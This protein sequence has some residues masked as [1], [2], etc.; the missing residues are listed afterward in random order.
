MSDAKFNI[1]T[2]GQLH[3]GVSEDTAVERLSSLLSIE[4]E[5]ARTMLQTPGTIIRSGLSYAQLQLL[6][7]KLSEAG[8]GVDETPDES[9]AVVR[10]YDVVFSGQSREYFR[11]WSVNLMLTLIT[12][13]FYSPWAKVRNNQ[14]LY[15]HV[16]LDQSA[17]QYTANPWAI[18][19]G[20][21]L[22]LVAFIAY[23]AA[24]TFL[25]VVGAALG[26]FFL[27][28]MPAIINRALSFQLANTRYRNLRFGFRGSYAEAAWVFLG[29]PFLIPLT[30]GMITPYWWYRK[31]RYL[32][33]R[34]YYGN[35]AFQF[36][37]RASDY[38][39]M[40][41][42]ISL[43]II[44]VLIA[45]VVLSLLDLSLLSG[46]LIAIGYLLAFSY[47]ATATTNLRFNFTTNRG[48][49]FRSQMQ[50][51]KMVSLYV[52]NT[53]LIVITLGLAIP[54]ARVRMARY[55]AKTLQVIARGSLN[56]FVAAE[57]EH[58]SA[59]GEQ[60]GEMFDVDIPVI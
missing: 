41:F 28:L 35:S 56:R 30:L 49:S 38:Y 34:L 3:A 17:F 39:H 10:E 13:G 20:R 54:V 4:P 22:A 58:V 23:T 48:V 16:Q 8:I 44:A 51:T 52:T 27:I 59:A 12:L 47:Y 7:M 21:L 37:A 14:Y 26:L 43:G 18:F 36:S 55:R 42:A 60:I 32:V 57:Q 31:E 45:V 9:D 24:S 1:V 5:A 11:I 19:R 25:P 33:D 15:S 29:L 2:T 40:A 46:V 53:L 50:V 6:S